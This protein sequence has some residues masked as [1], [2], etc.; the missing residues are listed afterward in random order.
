MLFRFLKYL[1]PTHYFQLFRKDG[2]S[3]FPIPEK[4]PK[5]ILLQLEPDARFTSESAKQY[6]L[7]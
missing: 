3:I 6:D 5:E 2:T 7:S 4:L 1:H